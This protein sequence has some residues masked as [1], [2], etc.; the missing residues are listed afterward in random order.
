MTKCLL[1]RANKSNK[2]GFPKGKIN[3]NEKEIDCAIREIYEEVGFDVTPYIKEDLYFEET[4]PKTQRKI[5]LYIICGIPESTRFETKTRG[6]IDDIKWF[7]INRLHYKMMS[8]LAAQNTL[9]KLIKWVAKNKY[10]K[11]P[12]LDFKFNMNRISACFSKG[13]ECVQI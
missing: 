4:Y 11:D 2:W 13:K 8:G 10:T 3:K 6:E 12:L 1:I 5:R 9:E 7:K